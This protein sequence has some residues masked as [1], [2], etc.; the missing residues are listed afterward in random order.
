MTISIH[1]Y[2]EVPPKLASLGC[3]EPLSVTLLP[4]NFATAQTFGEL[5][6]ESNCATVRTLL[7]S[8][9]IE[10]KR[11]EHEGA[12]IPYVQEN[13]FTWVGPILFFA[14]AEV[15]RNPEII[16]VALGVIA[17]YLTDFFRGIPGGRRVTFDVVIEQTRSKKTVRVHYDGSPEGFKELPEAIVE[18]CRDGGTNQRLSDTPE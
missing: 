7:R 15:S 3:R 12:K 1:E 17:N 8:A 9:G 18:I 4:R 6:H 5:V 13:D 16:S 14:A 2:I 10:E 11:I